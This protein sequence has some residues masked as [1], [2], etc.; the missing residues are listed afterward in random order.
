MDGLLKK[1]LKEGFLGEH[2][3]LHEE[4]LDGSR[5]GFVVAL[6]RV[7]QA[8]ADPGRGHHVP[9]FAVDQRDVEGDRGQV[10]GSVPGV[11]ELFHV[12]LTHAGEDGHAF[13]RELVADVIHQIRLGG[14]VVVVEVVSPGLGHARHVGEH[15]GHLL[16]QRSTHH[17]PIV[18]HRGDRKMRHIWVD[19]HGV[20]PLKELFVSS[21]GGRVKERVLDTHDDRARGKLIQGMKERHTIKIISP[22][23]SL[24]FGG[25]LARNSRAQITPS[26]VR[27][28]FFLAQHDKRCEEVVQT[29]A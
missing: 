11:L 20:S 18:R 12:V 9:G 2:E 15:F 22:T 1:I 23:R 5:V 17:R 13:A 10:D 28:P 24:P 7:V 6:V 16:G 27:P 14:V 8:L 29:S 3:G 19:R 26:A 21:S 25:Q 4:V